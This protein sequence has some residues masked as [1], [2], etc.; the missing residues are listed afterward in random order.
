[1]PGPSLNAAQ[2]ASFK[3]RG[4][5][6]AFADSCRSLLPAQAESHSNQRRL[7]QQQEDERLQMV[8]RALKEAAEA[9][10][11][12]IMGTGYGATRRVLDET[13]VSAI[14]LSTAEILATFDG[15]YMY[16]NHVNE[17]PAKCDPTDG[18]AD[19]RQRRLAKS[20]GVE[21]DR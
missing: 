20:Q 14:E 15:I 19:C 7:R 13:D 18:S 21:G 6:Q 10:V 5:Q 2:A 11:N 9:E 3:R 16:N 4:H 1:M 17:E 8:R 12:D